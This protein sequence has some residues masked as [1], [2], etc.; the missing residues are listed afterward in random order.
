MSKL[1]LGPMLRYVD[2]NSATI[3]VETDRACRVSVLDAAEDTFCV[4]G[5]HYAIV[6]VTGLQPGSS[7]P[8]TVELDGQQVWPPAHSAWPPSLIRTTDPTTPLRLAFGSCRTGGPLNDDDSGVD[9]L[10]AL[11]E[12]MRGQSPD[13]WPDACLMIGDQVY[14]DDNISPAT[15]EF[16]ASHRAEDEGAGHEVGNFAEY[17]RLYEESWTPEPIRWLLSTLPSMM[18]FDDHDV[19]DDWNT[20]H[21]WRQQMQATSWWTER[22]TAGLMSYWIYQHLGNLSPTELAASPLLAE[23]RAAADAEKVLARFAEQA[24]AAA[25]GAP[26]VQWSYRRDFG[27]TRLVVLDSRCN[28]VVDGR[29]RLMVSDREWAWFCDQLDGDLDHLLIG[30]SLPYLLPPGIHALEAWD[31]GISAGRWGRLGARVGEKIR[32]AADLEHWAAFG[33]S[34]GRMADVLAEVGSGTRGS[35]PATITFL[36][37]D[38][39]FAYVAQATLPHRPQVTSRVVQAVCSPLRNPLPL[40]ARLAERLASSGIAWGIGRVMAGSVGSTPDLSWRV[41]H[42]PAF[43]NEIAGLVLDGRTFTMTVESAVGSDT[44]KPAL[45][46]AFSAHFPPPPVQVPG[47]AS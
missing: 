2:E 1:V 25:D 6:A 18:I 8:Y 13:Q 19:R 7:V 24:D 12:R 35:A 38:V 21:T 17:T 31:E 41:T 10:H 44:G 28:R 14:A 47:S 22:I 40:P 9:A 32:Q 34:F 11:A 20:S 33:E 3:W 42:G 26:G 29:Q 23:V 39:H 15:R 5:H 43:G 4:G 37:G 30:T 16:I 46:H 27:R 45:R 36:S